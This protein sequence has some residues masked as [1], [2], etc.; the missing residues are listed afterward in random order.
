MRYE[1]QKSRTRKSGSKRLPGLPIESVMSK[2]DHWHP[3]RY[4][5]KT[6]QVLRPGLR[7]GFGE[8]DLLELAGSGDVVPEGG[9]PKQG[10]V[11][12]A[13]PVI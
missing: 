1:E 10:F 7:A 5:F 6:D 4:I 2:T 11:V 3:H 9:V 8:R 13:P 12:H